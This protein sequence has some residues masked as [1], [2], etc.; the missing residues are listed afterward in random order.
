MNL[1][2]IFTGKTYISFSNSTRQSVT[3]V[4]DIVNDSNRRAEE[5]VVS[6]QERALNRQDDLRA[7]EEE[8]MENRRMN[9]LL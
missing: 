6:R 8:R 7:R 1:G 4:N 9:L 5:R 3:Q 2:I